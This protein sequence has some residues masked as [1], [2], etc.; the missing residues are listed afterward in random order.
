MPKPIVTIASA[1][2]FTRSAGSAITTPKSAAA[3]PLAT[4]ASHGFHSPR[5]V[6]S[7]TVYAPTANRP[8]WPRDFWPVWPT[9]TFRPAAAR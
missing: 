4:N 6:S 3:N 7:A 2:P 1:G 5:V 9:S 8:A